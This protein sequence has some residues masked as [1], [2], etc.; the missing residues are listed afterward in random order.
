MPVK[1]HREHSQR[2]RT[3]LKWPDRS[4]RYTPQ[5]R[6]AGTFGLPDRPDTSGFWKLSVF[7]LNGGILPPNFT[8]FKLF[9]SNLELFY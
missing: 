5:A 7:L 2:G 1:A 4:S 6:L 3:G 8:D 9:L